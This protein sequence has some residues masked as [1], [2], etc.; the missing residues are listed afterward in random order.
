M[1][2]YRPIPEWL[3]KKIRARDKKCVYCKIPFKNN[4]TD[5]AE[6]EHIDN[7]E[8]N[9]CEENVTLCCKSCNASK[10][11][12]KL[13]DWLNSPNKKKKEINKETVADI[14]KEYIRKYAL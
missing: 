6:W 10:G 7:D 2:N 14:I 4:P 9:I 8:N 5:R 12:K 11:D 3:K 1:V 13:M